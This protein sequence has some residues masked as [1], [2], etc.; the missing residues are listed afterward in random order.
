M[1]MR[2]GNGS[3]VKAVTSLLT[4]VDCSAASA[5]RGIKRCTSIAAC[6]TIGLNLSLKVCIRIRDQW[7][8]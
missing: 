6:H 1:Y 4:H 8:Q 5:G 2:N 7:K 3:L